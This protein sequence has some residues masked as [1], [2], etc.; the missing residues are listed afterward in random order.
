MLTEDFSEAI[1]PV[2]YFELIKRRKFLGGERHLLLAVL[3]EA[4]RCYLTN[5]NGR[6]REQVIRFAEVRRWFYPRSDQ[7]GLFAFESICDLL[8]IDADIFRRRLGS[9][10]LR[11]LPSRRVRWVPSVARQRNHALRSQ[12][13]NSKQDFGTAPGIEV[14]NGNPFSNDT[15]AAHRRGSCFRT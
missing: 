10:S 9:I 5:M 14:S 15:T 11:D 1:L 7:Q 8:G 3:E 2:Q 4:V 6:S 13:A 12:H